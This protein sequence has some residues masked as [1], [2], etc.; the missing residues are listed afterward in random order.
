VGHLKAVIALQDKLKGNQ[1]RVINYKKIILRLAKLK[2]LLQMIN[3]KDKIEELSKQ[4]KAQSEAK[5]NRDITQEFVLRSK[6]RDL[7]NECRV[8]LT[9]ITTLAISYNIFCRNMTNLLNSKKKSR[10][11]CKNSKPLLLG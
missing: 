5:G 7:N 6:L 9:K 11:S 4:Y 10:R 8:C 2:N 3:T 1:H